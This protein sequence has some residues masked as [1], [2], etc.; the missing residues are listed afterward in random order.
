MCVCVYVCTEVCTDSMYLYI[1]D[2]V[3]M[4]YKYG[5]PTNTQLPSP[6]PM[7]KIDL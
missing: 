1:I 4:F 2:V 5:L 6:A 7:L 3:N